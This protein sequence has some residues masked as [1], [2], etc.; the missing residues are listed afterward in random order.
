MRLLSVIPML[1]VA[2]PLFASNSSVLEGARQLYQRTE[3]RQALDALKNA[4]SSPEAHALAGR[5]Y[6]M[7]GDFKRAVTLLEQAVREQP[8]NAVHHLW[9][10]RA[11]GRRAESSNPFQAPIFAGR[12]RHAFEKSV[13]IDPANGEALSDLLE[14]YLQAPGFLGGGV[15]KAEA[16]APKFRAVSMSDYE[17]ARARIAVKKK[18]DSEAEAHYR[19]ALELDPGKPGRYTDLAGFLA[20]RGRLAEAEALFAQAAKLAP[21]DPGWRF[22]Q[23]QSYIDAGVKTA[24]ARRLLA[25]FLRL[26]LTPDHPSAGEARALLKRAGA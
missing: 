10:G 24:E 16:L 8:G 9:L 15:D 18:K 1:A 6:Y 5:C 23:A 12:A 21:Q 25:E 20:R 17:S 7:S 4:P 3:Y 13:Q 14:Y 2:L 11:W 22:A 19:R 26:P